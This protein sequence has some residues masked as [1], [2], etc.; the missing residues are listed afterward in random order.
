MKLWLLTEIDT[1]K[2]NYDTADGF[3][4]RARSASEARR[5]AALQA[6]DEAGAY[7]RDAKRS[8]CKMLRAKG[9]AGVILRDYHG[10]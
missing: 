4:V 2:P 10:G 7:W 1:N 9:R 5:L 6:G 3:V 8:K